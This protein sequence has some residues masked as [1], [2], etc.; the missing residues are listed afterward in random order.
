[1]IPSKLQR[2]QQFKPSVVDKINQIIDY[3]KTQR[4]IGDNKTIKVNQLANS[5]ALTAQPQ[6]SA[7]PGGSKTVNST[8]TIDEGAAVPAVITNTFSDFLQQYNVTLY[9]NGFGGSATQKAYYVL[10]TSLSFSVEPPYGAKIIVFKAY[11][12]SLGGDDQE[13]GVID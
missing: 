2:G 9:P 8:V 7:K 5:I 4:I 6:T 10:P 1:M 13:N 12:D 3:L 11:V